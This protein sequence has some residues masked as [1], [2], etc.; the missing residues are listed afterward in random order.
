MSLQIY[1]AHT[2]ERLLADPVSFASYVS[3]PP[4]IS[5]PVTASSSLPVEC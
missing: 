4:H 3:P 1:I 2:G 5:S